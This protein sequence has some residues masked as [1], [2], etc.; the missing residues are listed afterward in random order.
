[1]TMDLTKRTKLFFIVARFFGFFPYSFTTK[2]C[3]ASAKK[4]VG[5][6][7]GEKSLFW[8]IWSVFFTLL[9]LFMMGADIYFAI[10]QPRGQEIG[11]ETVVVIHK[12]YDVVTA[13][14]VMLLHLILW[15]RCDVVCPIFIQASD[16]NDLNFSPML[17]K[18]IVVSVVVITPLK[19][20]MYYMHL[21]RYYSFTALI[22][23][24]FKV[25]TSIYIFVYIG[26]LYSD[27]LAL[28]ARKLNKIFEPI[29]QVYESQRSNRDA[30]I[31]LTDQSLAHVVQL[32][33]SHHNVE[34]IEQ[35]CTN[36]FNKDLS[37]GKCTHF[38]NSSRI[39]YSARLPTLV[40]PQEQVQ[41]DE[42]EENVLIVFEFQRKINDY[43]ELP[44]VIIMFCLVTWLITSGFYALLWPILSH[45]QKYFI[46]LNFVA[47]I[48]PVMYF[49]N[50]T[51]YLSSKVEDID[52]RL[53]FLAHNGTMRRHSDRICSFVAT[54]IIILMQFKQTEVEA[55]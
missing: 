23:L 39:S 1:M 24:F 3:N 41:Y 43:T 4:S 45:G 33:T 19:C 22:P 18:L 9:S 28:M 34:D 16:L 35:K 12:I 10:S 36:S 8:S 52:W 47:T 30:C 55:K 31:G 17:S 48:I 25:V 37:P 40:L 29:F 50:S 15:W 27:I 13:V 14:S 7:L 2:P 49:T 6:I 53:T 32:K 42:I 5:N 20:A 26:I 11:F 51:D 46:A 44:M 54:Y 38:F 21:R